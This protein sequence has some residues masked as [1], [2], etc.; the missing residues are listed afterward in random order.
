[1]PQ[2][3]DRATFL[4]GSSAAIC[5]LTGCG[6]RPKEIATSP[7]LNYE[8]AVRFARTL[9]EADALD[10]ALLRSAFPRLYVH[11]HQVEHS[12]ALFHGFT[13]S[14]QQF[15]ELARGFFA[16]GCNV[17][18]PRI[19]RHGLKDRL[20][21]DLARLTIG[22]LERCALDAFSV[23][24]GLGRSTSAV[25]LSLGGTMV[26]WLTQTQSLD[27]AIPV[28]PFLMPMNVPQFLGAPA[29]HVLSV[30]PDMYWFWDSK[31]KERSLPAYAYPGYPSRSMAQVLSFADTI[32]RLSKTNKP[33]TKRCVLV[34][35]SHENA[36][37]NDVAR[38]L[39]STWNAHGSGYRELLL[40]NLG[41]P[42]H[43]IIDPTTFRSGRTLVYPVLEELVTR[44]ARVQ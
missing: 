3:I 35:N 37:S 10:S 21:R 31:L 13:N 17:F 38:Q 6:S 40:T 34:L 33:Q 25:G 39:L 2:R 42:R 11:G 20:T 43:D 4:A 44:Q 27:L 7:A 23:V 1:M 29:A 32:F 5:A 8:G 28:A 19:P 15:D 16:R 26:L 18:V 36:I 30:L 41:E 12:V 22:E 14:P 9:I 24:R